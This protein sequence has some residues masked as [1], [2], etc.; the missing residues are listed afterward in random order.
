MT[1]LPVEQVRIGKGLV[2][3]K[4]HGLA[5][6]CK[7][8]CEYLATD[9]HHLVR[10]SHLAGPYDFVEID[11]TPVQNVAGL[12]WLCHQ[13]I[14]QNKA[15][16]VWRGKWCWFADNAYVPLD[17]GLGLETLPLLPPESEAS[18]QRENLVA[19]ADDTSAS[20]ALSEDVLVAP[21]QS[22]EAESRGRAE[23]RAQNPPA[24]SES[25]TPDSGPGPS[26][27]QPGPG[28]TCPTCDRRIP[29]PK[30]ESSPKDTKQLNLGKAPADY[31][32]EI[33]QR[34]DDQAEAWGISHLP[35]HRWKVL[36][37]ALELSRHVTAGAAQGIAS[38]RPWAA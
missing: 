13:E 19:E 8:G 9:V 29:H 30:K 32:E 27:S 11:G 35:N 3:T 20:V 14:T 5:R 26:L 1:R 12:C 21:A 24:S 37:L 16:I 33:K 17:R 23:P 4:K 31:T 2:P 10:R 15:E 34:L 28:T 6:C 38:E 36:D 25:V 7:P 22:G 18:V